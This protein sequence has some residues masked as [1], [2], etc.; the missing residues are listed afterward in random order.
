VTRIV[1][2]PEEL[3]RFAGLATQAADEYGSRASALRSLGPVTMPPDVAATVAD[4][5]ARVASNLDALS[6][7]LYAEA[8]MLRARAAVLDPVLRRYLVTG[9]AEQP[10]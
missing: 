1:V 5:V 10:G 7:G 2:D 6:A 9:P 3:D 8:M 4:A